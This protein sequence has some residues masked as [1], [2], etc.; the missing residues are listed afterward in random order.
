MLHITLFLLISVQNMA[1]RNMD[2]LQAKVTQTKLA[3]WAH[4]DARCDKPNPIS[5]CTRVRAN[6]VATY[7]RA[8]TSNSDVAALRDAS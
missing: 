3:D 2:Q 1:R 5:A 4:T 8:P 7:R 6:S